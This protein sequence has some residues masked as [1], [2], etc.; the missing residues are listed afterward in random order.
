[1]KFI[2]FLYAVSLAF[3]QTRIAATQIALV[4]QVG[5]KLVG[6]TDES[7][8]RVCL[9]STPGIYANAYAFFPKFPH[10][11]KSRSKVPSTYV[12][13]SQVANYGL[14]VSPDGT[15]LIIDNRWQFVATNTAAVG[16]LTLYFTTILDFQLT[17]LES[18]DL[19]ERSKIG[20]WDIIQVPNSRSG[21][22]TVHLENG[23]FHITS[24]YIVVHNACELWNS[25]VFKDIPPWP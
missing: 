18:S 7:F 14:S 23:T 5:T 17:G 24:P 25:G 22:V 13:E 15:T 4:P 19:E 3:S 6:Q 9:T 11:L 21:L 12:Q 2:I 1:M 8:R 16:N 20:Q 10:G